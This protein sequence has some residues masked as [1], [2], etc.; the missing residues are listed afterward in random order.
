MSS[1]QENTIS[2]RFEILCWLLISGIIFL[3]MLYL[4]LSYEHFD[5][6][7][8][9]GEY[10]NIAASV[11]NGGGFSDA[12]GA[13]G[14]TT[15]WMPPLYVAYLSLLFIAFGTK[16]S[17]AFIVFLLIK[18]C[19]IGLL[20]FL[21]SNLLG[22]AHLNATQKRFQFYWIGFILF[23]YTED[24]M[25]NHHDTWFLAVL[26]V[27][28]LF[29]LLQDNRSVSADF[30][31]V[32]LVALAPLASPAIAWS[33]Y[34]VLILLALLR[35][36][37]ARPWGISQSRVSRFVLLSCLIAPML[38][39]AAWTLRN[40]I[41]FD[42]FIPIK[43]NAWYDLEQALVYTDDGV[44]SISTFY[45]YHPYLQNETGREYKELRELSFISSKKDKVV[46]LSSSAYSQW[47]SHV[48]NRCIN[49]LL[50]TKSSSDI[51]L[52][53]ADLDLESIEILQDSELIIKKPNSSHYIW[54]NLGQSIENLS[55]HLDSTPEAF[56]KKWTPYLVDAHKRC[57]A[58]QPIALLKGFLMAGFPVCLL[59]YLFFKCNGRTDLKVLILTCLMMAY[60]LPYLLISHYERY[61]IPLLG[62]HLIL[63]AIILQRR[64]EMK[65][66]GTAFNLNRLS[67]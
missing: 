5:L 6:V 60:L 53:K 17:A 62:I 45:L 32:L 38:T 4:N 54:L 30:I 24:L 29:L 43:S 1:H 48:L 14:G 58:N 8:F 7:D 15:A 9:A 3:G 33:F 64:A 31:L 44:P 18:A 55:A 50:Y 22:V 41:H 2:Q 56:Q 66:Q 16:S 59:L 19:G 13:G 28:F 35:L 57:Y 42:Q 40:F 63:G 10:G 65:Q 27:L 61:Q 25:M 37:M 11:A 36:P 49:A 21:S 12:M 46:Q 34:C 23:L 20:G 26:I 67:S 39:T 52:V 51:E 47:F